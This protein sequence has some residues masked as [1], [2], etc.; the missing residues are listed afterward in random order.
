MI[1]QDFMDQKE[2]LFLILNEM[3]K[4][5]LRFFRFYNKDATIRRT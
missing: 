2:N 4:N 1:K 5:L 3:F